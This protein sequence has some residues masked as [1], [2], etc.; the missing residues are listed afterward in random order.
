MTFSPLLLC[1]SHVFFLLRLNIFACDL[2]VSVG[3]SSRVPLGDNQDNSRDVPPAAVIPLNS[4]VEKPSGVDEEGGGGRWRDG[5][6][7]GDS[8]DH[9]ADVMVCAIDA[10]IGVF[11][12]S[13]GRRRSC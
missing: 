12:T 2:N 7:G 6:G 1:V 8:S 3:D 4:E 11:N 5:G 9:T 10:G 13:P